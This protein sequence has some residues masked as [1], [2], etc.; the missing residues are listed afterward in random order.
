[1]MEGYDLDDFHGNGLAVVVETD[2]FQERANKDFSHSA[3]A[4][5]G[6]GAC[7]DYLGL[8]DGDAGVLLLDLLLHDDEQDISA[9][10]QRPPR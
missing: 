10:L 5:A 6:V 9:D 4:G 2:V 1:M 7:R 3:G 8:D